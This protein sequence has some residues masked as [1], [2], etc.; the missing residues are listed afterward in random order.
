M[1]IAPITT[2][3]N[4]QKGQLVPNRKAVQSP[5]HHGSPAFRATEGETDPNQVP[6]SDLLVDPITRKRFKIDSPYNDEL[7]RLTPMQKLKLDF[8]NTFVTMPKT[9]YQGLRGNSHFTFSDYLSVTSIPYYLGGAFLAASAGFGRDK[10]NMSRQGVGVLLYYLGVAAANKGINAF[11]KAKAGIDL[12][13]RYKKANG[14]IEKVFAST[15]FPRFDLLE[16]PDYQEM[17][18]K[19]HIPN[20]VSDPKREAND[21]ARTIISAS[22]ADKLILG[23]LLAAIG[24]G[25]LARSDAWGR[26]P[27]GLKSIAHIWSL[28]NKDA[29][30]LFQ[31]M[32]RTGQAISGTVGPALRETILGYH[33]EPNPMWRKGILGSMALLTGLIFLHSWQAATRNRKRVYE[34]PFTSNLSPA[35]SPEQSAYTA[36]VQQHLP[37]GAINKLPRKGVF[38]VVQRIESGY[39]MSLPEPMPERR[40]N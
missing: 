25:Y 27:D 3:P 4:Q 35:L 17:M 34:S 18:R 40:M 23:N 6:V 15:D 21:Q 2:Y 37:G 26:V 29:G 11:Y 1:G 12:D 13:L 22:R 30:G 8:N 39:G 16:D 28:Q 32:T 7:M 24:A 14:D 9:I 19:M 10:M 5:A 20:N 33:G 38:D 36:A 31:R